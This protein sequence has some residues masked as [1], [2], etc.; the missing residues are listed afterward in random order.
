MPFRRIFRRNTTFPVV[1]PKYF[2]QQS[3]KYIEAN[4]FRYMDD[5]CIALPEDLDPDLLQCALNELKP[6][7]EFTM[8]KG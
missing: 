7:V 3:C 2:S 4:Y 1:L 6:S 8:E 5:G